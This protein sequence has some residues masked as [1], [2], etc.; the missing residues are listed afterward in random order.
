MKT[1]I[2]IN[3]LKFKVLLNFFVAYML[4]T[5]LMVIIYQKQ[6]GLNMWAFYKETFIKI[7]PWL[8]VLLTLGIALEY[9]NPMSA[10]IWRFLVNSF[11]LVLFYAIVMIVFVWNK[12]EKKLFTDVFKNVLKKRRNRVTK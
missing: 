4:R 8:I 11:V 7:T 5:V 9:F 1:Y 10:S 2:F 3:Y 12:S 6:M